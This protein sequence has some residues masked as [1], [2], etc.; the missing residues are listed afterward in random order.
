MAEHDSYDATG[1]LILDR[2]TP[3]ITA[4]FGAFHLDASY[5]GQ[6]QASIA[7]TSGSKD[8]QWDDVRD[9]LAHLSANLGLALPDREDDPT[10]ADL[11]PAL[12]AH[13]GVARDEELDRLIRHGDF[14]GDL[15]LE[16]LFRLALRFDGGH[17]LTVLSFAGCWHCSPPRLFEFGG[18]ACY[19]SREVCLVGNTLKIGKLGMLLR[20]AVRKADVE[21]ASSLLMEET[22]DLLSSLRDDPFHRQV[23]RRL[24]E[25]LTA[26]ARA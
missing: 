21:K 2:V 15:D 4:L 23:L 3:V 8:P 26:C 25:R 9:G 5:P 10:V 16:V 24:A 12:A 19:L 20:D 7:R 11:L 13:F 22:V 6:G 17:R 14:E 18:D 1:V